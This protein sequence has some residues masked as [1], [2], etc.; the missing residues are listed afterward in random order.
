MKPFL[1]LTWI[2]LLA[3]PYFGH[4]Q[5]YSYTHYDLSD[6]LAGSTVYSIAQDKD[7]FIWASTETGVSRF[8][9]VHFQ[10]FTTKDGLPDVEILRLFGDSRDRVWMAPFGKSICYY[11]KGKIHNQLNDPVLRDVGVRGLID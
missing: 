1:F 2:I 7:G 9:G 6:G 3:L 8:D 5:G 11:Y 10:N 4:S